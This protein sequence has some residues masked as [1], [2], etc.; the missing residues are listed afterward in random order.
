MRLSNVSVTYRDQRMRRS[1][2]VD[3]LADISASIAPGEKVGLIGANGAGKSTLLRVMAGILRPNGGVIERNG[4]RASLLSLSAG[5]DMDLSGVRNVVLHGMLTGLT[6]KEAAAR[7]PAV[8]ERAGLGDAIHRRVSTY[9][10]GMRARLCFWTAMSLDADVMLIDEVLSVGD[11][12]FREKSRAAMQ[13]LMRG[14]QTVVLASHNLA[15]VGGLCDRVIWLDDGRVRMDD[16]AE[17]VLEEY[18]ALVQPPKEPNPIRRTES[19]ERRQ[20]FVCGAA[21]SGTTAMTRLLNTHPDIVVGIER[22]KTRLLRADDEEDLP[23]L[24]AKERF[25]D[26]DPG[27][28]NVNYRRSYR[29][30]M[31]RAARKFDDAV[32]IGD[33]VPNLYRR[34]DFIAAKFPDCRVVY[35]LRD[36]LH[37]AASWQVRALD[38]EDAWPAE[39]DYRQAVA[40]WN[41]SVRIALAARKNLGPRI[42]YVSYERVFGARGWGVW[43]ELMRRLE[44]SPKANTLTRNFMQKSI[45]RGRAARDVPED[46]RAYVAEHADLGTYA[47]LLVA[48][49]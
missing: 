32:Y 13:D 15:F 27:D 41:E 22:F 3:A 48:T 46:V 29:G 2:P 37:V 21:R 33:K 28:T 23:A 26:Y 19:R 1:G 25:F 38:E 6:P 43:R 9:S 5:F 7:V 12:E 31:E 20:L 34:L 35:M 11:Q 44:L 45:R 10:T 4:M 40:D 8:A 36:P 42:S 17:V 18:R 47:E 16:H 39:N 30:D 14:D 24:F 49:L